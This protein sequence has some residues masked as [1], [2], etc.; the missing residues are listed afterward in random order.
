MKKVER[1]EKL[2]GVQYPTWFQIASPELS[3]TIERMDGICSIPADTSYS[4]THSLTHSVGRSVGQSV[5][6]SKSIF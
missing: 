6:I 4:L 1:Q 2:P 5:K 3:N